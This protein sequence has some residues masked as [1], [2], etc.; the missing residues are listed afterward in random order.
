MSR[1]SLC[2]GLWSSEGEAGIVLKTPKCWEMPE[3][4]DTCQGESMEPAQEKS[5]TVNKA[6]RRWRSED[7]F[8][9]RT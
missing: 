8:D 7:R 1:A 5:V 2:G 9:V 3:Q 4:W 6:E